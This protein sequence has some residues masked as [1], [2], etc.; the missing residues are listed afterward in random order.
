MEAEALATSTDWGPTAAAFRELMRSW[1]E[2]GRADRADEEELWGRF[3]AAQD[4]F[5]QARSE[6]L[7]GQGGRAARARGGQGALLAEAEKLLPVT[8]ARAARAALR[9]IQERWEQ[10]GP[11]PREAHD[12]LE[13]GLRRVEE[14]VRKAEDSQWRRS[15]PE[16][17]ARAK[18]TVEQIRA[19][20]SQLEEQLAKA[21]A[22]RRHPGAARRPRRRSPPAGP[23]WRKPSAP[24]P[25]CPAEPAQHGYASCRSGPSPAC[26]L[27]DPVDVVDAVDGADRAQHVAEVLGV[28]HLEREPAD[29][30]PV[31]GRGHRRGQDVHVLVGDGPGDVGEQAGPVQRLDLD[32]HQEQRALAWATSAPRPAAPAG[33][34]AGAAG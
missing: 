1:K 26:R 12:R 14:A 13:Q 7:L 17:L 10:A 8:N 2:A 23:G 9:A 21:Q 3:K 28:A 30:D 18:G 20:I 6:V 19:A 32:G 11:V 34:R 16:A 31:P 29:R 25:S 27:R 22:A 24:W 4:S 15:N 5:F 33:S